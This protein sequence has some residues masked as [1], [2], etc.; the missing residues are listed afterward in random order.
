[1]HLN[2]DFEDLIRHLNA[3]KVKY[4]VV[5]A[6]AVIIHSFPRYTKDIDFLVQP[7]SEN[8]QKVYDALKSFGAPIQELSLKDLCDPDMVYQMGVEPNRADI[9]MSV[10][11]AS[12]E[13]LWKNKKEFQ[14]G[15]EKIFVVGLE[16]LIKIKKMAGRPKDL[17]DAEILLQAAKMSKK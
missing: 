3:A 6:Y 14:Y 5:G 12:F 2:Q 10:K 4:L 16:D 7:E 11:G 15:N 1:M 13:E 8:A 9:I 17:Q